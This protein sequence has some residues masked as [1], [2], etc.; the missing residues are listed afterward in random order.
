MC[1]ANLENFLGESRCEERTKSCH[2]KVLGEFNK[3]LFFDGTLS[4]SFLS[5]VRFWDAP[6]S[7]A[8]LCRKTRDAC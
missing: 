3:G 5:L 7:T 8:P 1:A 2:P 4:L 6:H